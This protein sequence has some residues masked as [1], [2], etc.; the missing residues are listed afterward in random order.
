MLPFWRYVDDILTAV[1]ANEVN[2]IKDFFNRYNVNIQFTVEEEKD[3]SIS[4][5]ELLIIRDDRMLRTDWCHKKTW[6]GRY[7]NFNSHLPITYKRN[8]ISLLTEKI[9]LLSEPE[10]HDKNFELLATTLLRNFYPRKLIDDMVGKT[11]LRFNVVKRKA[12]T[13]K[14]LLQL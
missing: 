4:F 11:K 14:T 12:K 13:L 3:C 9:L 10:F 7:L 6:S 1:P 5:L 2:K 8:T